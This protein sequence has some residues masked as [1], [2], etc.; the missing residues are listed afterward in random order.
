MPQA[1]VDG[2]R[3]R[4]FSLNKAKR[5][6]YAKWRRNRFAKHMGFTCEEHKKVSN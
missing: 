2:T 5:S 3:K 6:W 4:R 1:H